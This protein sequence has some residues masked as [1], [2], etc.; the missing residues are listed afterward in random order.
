MKSRNSSLPY[1]CPFE[2]KSLWQMRFDL[3]RQPF[4]S[5]TKISTQ[6]AFQKN[7]V[8]VEVS[9]L[10]QMGDSPFE[11]TFESGRPWGSHCAHLIGQL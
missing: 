5:L 6:C 9:G 4:E 1:F 11:A 10:L 8:H 3:L 7:P 2:K